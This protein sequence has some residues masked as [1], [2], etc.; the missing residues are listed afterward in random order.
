MFDN[1]DWSDAAAVAG[2]VGAF[3]ALITALGKVAVDII[4]AAVNRNTLAVNEGNIE[5]AGANALKVAAQQEM[6]RATPGAQP[7]T[8]TNLPP[9]P[10]LEDPAIREAAVKL[11]GTG[12][13]GPNVELSETERIRSIV[14][15]EMANAR[16]NPERHTPGV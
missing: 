16:A 5:A 3:T 2:I 10:Q 15:S 13:G 4:T 6:L 11:I 14:L 12:D 1:F 9:A 7:L 8:P